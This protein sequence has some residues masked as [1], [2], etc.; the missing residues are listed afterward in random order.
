MLPIVSGAP[1]KAKS[2]TSQ[3]A[4]ALFQSPQMSKCIVCGDSE[5]FL[6]R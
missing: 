5:S 2:K 4:Q 1:S 3:V 6:Q